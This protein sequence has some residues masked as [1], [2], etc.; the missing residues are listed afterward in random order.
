MAHK[1]KILMVI[2]VFYPYTGGAEKQAAKLALELI[3]NNVG[4][5]VI[6]GRW[7]N[8][9]K[10]KEELNGIRILRNRTNLI[11]PRKDSLDTGISFFRP[12]D[13][14][15]LR[16]LLHKIYVRLCVYFY[17]FSLLIYLLCHGKE[18]DVIHVHQ[19]LYPAF[20]STLAA[21]IIKKPVIAKVGSSG[22]NSDINQIKKFPEGKC[23]L[24]YI[25]KHL[26]RLVCTSSNMT[27]EFIEAGMDG[28]K[29]VLIR[30]GV[31]TDDFDRSYRDYRRLAY[32]GRFINS[33][34]IPTL[35]SAFS[36]LLKKYTDLKLTLI[37]DGPERENI[38]HLVKK[39]GLQNNIIMTGMVRDP[40]SI[41]KK[42]DIFI[43]PSLIEGLSNSLIEAMSLKLPCIVTNIP[44]NV[45]VLG[46]SRKAYD[47]GRGDFM[48][49]GSGIM[50]NTGDI[51][52]IERAALYLIENTDARQRLGDNAYQRIKQEFDIRNV[53]ESYIRLYEEATA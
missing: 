45:E 6:T 14:K 22:S 30:N 53:A 34:D 33:K 38:T 19:V 16:S 39:L 27:E 9:L 7:N 51:E 50:V 43:F 29:I 15:G 36:R 46:E 28:R 23:Q 40:A 13:G 2:A 17:Q 12:H 48:E 4:V 1:F 20:I 8:L 44:G 10:K 24:K 5:T 26:D 47:I 32:L 41:L 42:N 25:L 31:S 52:A 35:L 49:S 37:G 3:K 21:A 18:H 11:I